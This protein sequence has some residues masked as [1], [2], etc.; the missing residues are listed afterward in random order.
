[1]G[2]EEELMDTLLLKMFRS[3]DAKNDL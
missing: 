2:S 3:V 1:L